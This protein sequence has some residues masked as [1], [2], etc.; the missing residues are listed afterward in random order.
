MEGLHPRRAHRRR[1]WLVALVAVAALA[2]AACG[3]DDGGSSSDTTRGASPAGPAVVLGAQDF[4]ESIVLS[5]VYA[6]ALGNAGYQARVQELGGYRDLLYGAFETGDVNFAVEYAGSLLNFL[7]TP[8]KPAGTDL[9]AN[10]SALTP[11]LEAKSVVHGKASEAVNTN[12]FVMTK[13]RSDELGITTLSDLAAKGG[14]L[15]LG[16]PSDC[17]TNSFCIPGLQRVYGVDLSGGFVSLD[18]AVADALRG[19]QFDVGVLFSTDPPV[20]ADDLV[21]LTDD[22]A[23]L[24]ADNIVPVLS[25]ALVEAY[26][27]PFVDLVDRVSAALT[28]ENV[29]AMNVAYVDD[30]EDASAI[31]EQFLE[32][33]D[34][35]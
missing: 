32:E 3:S 16:G 30:R 12:V 17:E 2:L 27:Q 14:S 34:L 10:V 11:L 19:G 20:S 33:H 4:A 25:D 28:T 1:S 29:Q 31:A 23:M 13:A 7:A 8:D 35:S 24:P 18:S 22:K 26:G 5:E 15:R 6:Q 9:E 21:V